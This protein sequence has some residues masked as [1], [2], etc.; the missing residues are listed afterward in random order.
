[1]KIHLKLFI[2]LKIKF[3]TIAGPIVGISFKK[4]IIFEATCDSDHSSD[5]QRQGDV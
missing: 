3:R 2:N 4:Y 1:M 5:L